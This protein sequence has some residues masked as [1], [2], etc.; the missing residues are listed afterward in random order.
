MMS[1]S[2]STAIGFYKNMNHLTLPRFLNQLTDEIGIDRL[3]VSNCYREYVE[4]RTVF[5]SDSRT[6]V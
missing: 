2:V 5:E 1:K 3:T 6:S 4:L